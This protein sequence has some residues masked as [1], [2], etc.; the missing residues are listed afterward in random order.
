LNKR[1]ACIATLHVA[2]GIQSMLELLAAGLLDAEE[3]RVILEAM[4]EGD[5]YL[6]TGVQPKEYKSGA[7]YLTVMIHAAKLKMGVSYYRTVLKV[8]ELQN[9]TYADVS[10]G[11]EG[12]EDFANSVD[13]VVGFTSEPEPDLSTRVF[14]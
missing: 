13:I 5:V 1:E 12:A 14:N 3:A 9:L 7:H 10:Q 8:L 4:R 11:I 6:N 2:M